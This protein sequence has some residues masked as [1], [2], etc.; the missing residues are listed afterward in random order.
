MTTDKMK[1]WKIARRVAQKLATIAALV[2]LGGLLSATLVRLAPGFDADE[3]ELDPGLNADSVRALRQS[4]AGE[5]DIFS[6]YLGYLRYHLG[7]VVPKNNPPSMR[8]N[9][10]IHIW[11]EGKSIL[12][13]DS[14]EHEVYNKSDGLR[15]VLIVDLL[16]PMPRPLHAIN[17][18][19]THV[20]GRHS[21]EAK[22]IMANIKK[23]S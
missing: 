19:L 3:R 1:S 2:L 13:D 17:T 10:Q 12:F 6:F 4:H 23:Y 16:R 14:W 8:V 21:E 15:V 18:L 11:E 5:H 20:L 22:Q 7:L 9:D